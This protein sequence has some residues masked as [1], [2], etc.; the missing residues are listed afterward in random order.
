VDSVHRGRGGT[1]DRDHRW[2]TGG[3]R[4]GRLEHGHGSEPA[5]PRHD[6][7]RRTITGGEWWRER[8]REG[9]RKGE[10]EGDAHQAARHR[11]E[12]R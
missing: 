7:L 2:S 10:E 11:T 12:A 5:Q 4:A 6:A 8:A 9:W 1:V 3:H